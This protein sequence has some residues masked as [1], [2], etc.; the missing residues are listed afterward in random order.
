MADSLGTIPTFKP[1]SSV[2]RRPR[3]TKKE[4]ELVITSSKPELVFDPSDCSALSDQEVLPID[5]DQPVGRIKDSIF[6]TVLDIPVSD[7]DSEEVLIAAIDA[8]N[9]TELN[10]V[11]DAID[12]ADEEAELSADPVFFDIDDRYAK[13]AEGVNEV[14]TNV[15]E[16]LSEESFWEDD[17]SDDDS[18][19]EDDYDLWSDV[20]DTDEDS[21]VD[22]HVS[23]IV[24]NTDELDDEYPRKLTREEKDFEY[25]KSRRDPGAKTVSWKN[26]RIVAQ[27]D[28]ERNSG[29]N[30]TSWVD[31]P[32]N[33]ADMLRDYKRRPTK[34][35]K[36]AKLTERYLKYCPT[37]LYGRTWIN[38]VPVDNNV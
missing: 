20:M 32:E 14:K 10:A 7:D 3:G 4:K 2:I 25:K 1:S 18:P 31:A 38:N 30:K 6:I 33:E 36:A 37:W 17:F 24:I 5:L 28:G 13:M 15:V 29:H 23:E 19:P 8:K 26:R 11:L 22:N 12:A 21:F 35:S 16:W 27:F 9:E 34:K